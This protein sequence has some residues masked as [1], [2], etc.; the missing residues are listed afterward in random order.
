MNQYSD[1]TFFA[2]LGLLDV[3]KAYSEY[4]IISDRRTS[5]WRKYVT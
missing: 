4:N 5:I 3:P 1:I 2:V